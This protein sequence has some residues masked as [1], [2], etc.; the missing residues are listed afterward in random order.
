MKIENRKLI[1][2]FLNNFKINSIKNIDHFLDFFYNEI[3]ES[4][5]NTDNILNNN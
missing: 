3:Q 4:I 5:Q 1:D 2:Y